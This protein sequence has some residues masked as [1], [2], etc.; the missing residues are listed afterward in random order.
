MAHKYLQE[1]VHL[2][3]GGR[4]WFNH[5]TYQY[6]GLM[7]HWQNAHV[8]VEEIGFSP[9]GDRIGILE[10]LEAVK[11]EN[12]VYRPLQVLSLSLL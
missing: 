12:S 11:K 3:G 2:Q 9:A 6:L 4:L 7:G 10:F 5:D 1:L 8:K